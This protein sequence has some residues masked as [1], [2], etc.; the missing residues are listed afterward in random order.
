[1][2]YFY[3]ETKMEK[4]GNKRTGTE[5]YQ[6]AYA[7]DLADRLRQAGERP[8][9]GTE[10][11]ANAGHAGVEQQGEVASRESAARLGRS[12]LRDGGS[13]VP[14]EGRPKGMSLWE[15]LHTPNEEV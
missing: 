2:D 3:R 8:P 7:A 13:V 10:R 11:T 15:W 4:R 14:Q 5:D 9:T 12:A 1:M 6:G